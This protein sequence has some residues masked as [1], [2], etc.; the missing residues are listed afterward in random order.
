MYLLQFKLSTVWRTK[1][2]H[3]NHKQLI[4]F[5]VSSLY[6]DEKQVVNVYK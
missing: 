2:Y 6:Y 1:L 4:I 3:F 5:G